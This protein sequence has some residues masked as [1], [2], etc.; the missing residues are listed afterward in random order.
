MPYLVDYAQS[1]L[2]GAGTLNANMPAHQ[3]DDILIAYVTVDSGTITLPTSGGGGGAWAALPS[4]PANPVTNT[5]VTYLA[6]LKASGS[7]ETFP[8]VVMG[9]AY[10]CTIYCFRDCYVAGTAAQIFDSVTPINTT[11]AAGY[12]VTSSAVTTNTA[13]SLIVY[14]IAQSQPSTLPSSV[15]SQPGVMWIDQNDTGGTTATTEA[16]QTAAWYMQRATGAPCPTPTF[17]SSVSDAFCKVTF[18]LRNK[19]AGRIPAYIDDVTSP[20]SMITGGHHIV[21]ANNIT[22]TTNG[23]TDT[24]NSKTATPGTAING[25]D[26]GINPFCNALSLAA[27]ATAK[28]ALVGPEI[29]LTA[30]L[31]ASAGL[32]IGSFIAGSPKMGTFGI[33]TVADGGVV[34]R[35]GSGSAGTTIWN[36]YQVAAKDSKVKTEQRCVFA[37]EAGYAGSAYANGAGGNCSASAVKFLQ[38]LRNAP[39]FSSAVYMSELHYVGRQVIAGGDSTTPVGITGL[40]EVGKSFRLPVIQQAGANGIVSFA[41]IQIGGGDAVYFIVDAGAIQFPSRASAS[42]KDIQYHASDNKVGLYLAGKSGDTIKLTNSVVTAATPYIFEITSGAT[43]AAT[44]DLSGLVL[45]G[46]NV[47]LRN[48]MTFL[49]MS[50]SSCPTLIFSGCS[51]DGCAISKVPADN[52]TLTTDASTNI[53][54]CTINVTGVSSGNRWCSVADPSIFSGCTFIGS[55]STGH[56]I[57]ITTPGTYAL[58]GNLFSGFGANGTNYA[59]IFNDSAGEVILNISGGGNTP[60]YR[61]GTSASTTVNANVQVTLTGLKNPSEV[62]VFSQGTTNEV[63]GTGAE[64]VTDGDHAFSIGSG[65]AVDIVILALGYQ[66]MR[67]LNYST[68][69]DA[70]I[71]ISQVLDRQYS[72]V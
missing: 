72:N 50:F 5:I 12:T 19:A 52:D 62:R 1:F 14:L 56:A 45:V 29:T 13:D 4:A 6:Y 30:A 54:N 16:H 68:T 48:V 33:G 27:A 2:N 22:C 65:V 60:T 49:G 10:T 42:A 51:L 64:N 24:I 41:P 40:V 18:A 63:G 23:I 37:I 7:A 3:A 43:S 28:T 20:G 53:D 69:A 46:A 11:S 36:A 58:S 21:A 71:P 35:L 25:A 61:N 66:N 26:F 17:V 70:S 38:F 32:I 34:V 15:L 44:W 47:T 67:I 8:G 9:D 59:A 31:D 55:G 39:Y 57:R